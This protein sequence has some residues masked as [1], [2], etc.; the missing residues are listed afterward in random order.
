VPQGDFIRWSAL[1]R[2]APPAFR[3][4]LFDIDDP[5]LR[6]KFVQ[7]ALRWG[8]GE[9]DET[10]MRTFQEYEKSGRRL[11]RVLRQIG[12][13]SKQ[14][15]SSTLEAFIHLSGLPVQADVVE[16]L[17]TAKG[18]TGLK[19]KRRWETGIKKSSPA[20]LMSGGIEFKR[21]PAG[22]FLM[23]SKEE[24]PLAFDDAH[25]QHT[26]EIPQEYWIGRYPVTNAQFR[27]FVQATRYRTTAEEKG[28]VY[29]GLE[30]DWIAPYGV[31]WQHP[32]GPES[33]L[34]GK[35]EHPVV[36]V[37]WLDA[38]AYCAWLNQAHADKLPPGWRFRLPTEA[39]WEKAARGEYAS[40]Y[41][42][43][44]EEPDANRCNF[45]MNIGDTTPVGQ[46]SPQGDSP[47]GCADMA[48]NVWEWTHTLFENYP[49]EVTDGREDEKAYGYRVLRGG[50][51]DTSDR[52]IRCAYHTKNL[53]DGRNDASGFR[54]V[55]SPIQF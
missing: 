42:W 41:P 34:E 15:S 44:S 39:E 23:G 16:A 14:W 47:Y 28:S 20:A 9:G 33:S 3:E 35:D 45:N 6:L 40:E 36:L 24:N 18:E 8:A 22:K 2:A 46:F 55:A 1:L 4:R 27:A 5:D 29:V 7:D 11:R 30:R 37:S 32:W 10:V 53:T 31:D 49:Y 50:S 21:I 52:Y 48:G 26:V 17:P 43:G 19:E 13:F 51:F 25:P 54:V 12:A 38:Q